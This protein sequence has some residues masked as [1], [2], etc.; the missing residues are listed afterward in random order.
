[1]RQVSQHASQEACVMLLGNKADLESDRVV[2]FA[3]A[4]ELAAEYGI[5]CMETSAKV[6]VHSSPK[7]RPSKSDL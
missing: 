3:E 6:F 2:D 5:E 4:K 1:M 7:L